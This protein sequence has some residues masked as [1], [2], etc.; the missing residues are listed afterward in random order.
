M[1]FG[2]AVNVLRGIPL[3]STL[4]PPKLKLLAFASE[5]QT[6]ED[7]EDLFKEGD[8]SD[9]AYLID[10]GAVDIIA[11]SEAKEVFVATLGRHEIFGEMGIFR[12]APRVATIRA[13]GHVKVLRIEAD[14]FLDLVTE[15]PE[16]ALAVMRILS[17]KIARTTERFEEM[18]DKIRALQVMDETR[19]GSADS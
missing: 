19:A 5:S 9:C 6:Y 3:F 16:T 17:E 1:E 11:A 18:D 4:E 10:E 2:D 13:K 7:G 14:M 12:N 15:N 8:P